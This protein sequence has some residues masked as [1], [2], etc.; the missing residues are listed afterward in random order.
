MSFLAAGSCIAAM[1][2]S[3]PRSITA[4]LARYHHHYHFG[5]RFHRLDVSLLFRRIDVCDRLATRH[6]YLGLRRFDAIAF[7]ILLAHS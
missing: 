3:V 2:W 5:R 1:P 6:Y 7:L 4:L